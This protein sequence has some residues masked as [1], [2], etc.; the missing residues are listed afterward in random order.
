[1]V[2]V[3]HAAAR[4][5]VDDIEGALRLAEDL[6]RPAQRLPSVPT[7]LSPTLI[8]VPDTAEK[9]PPNPQ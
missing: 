7:P 3:L 1:M 9:S 2:E 6:P 8:F 4:P 5:A